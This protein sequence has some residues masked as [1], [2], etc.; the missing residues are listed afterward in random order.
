[1]SYI[2]GTSNDETISY[3]DVLGILRAVDP[4]A[5]SCSGMYDLSER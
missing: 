2:L 1:L 3:E 5:Y 4:L